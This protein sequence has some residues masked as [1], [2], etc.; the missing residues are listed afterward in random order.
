MAE[1]VPAPEVAPGTEWTTTVA[2][3]LGYEWRVCEQARWPKVCPAVLVSGCSV[4]VR[5]MN[6]GIKDL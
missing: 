6:K 4:S 3:P 5:Q 2:F 1:Y